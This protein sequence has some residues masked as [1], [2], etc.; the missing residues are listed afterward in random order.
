MDNISQ[1]QLGS[2]Y[3]FIPKVKFSLIQSTSILSVGSLN[4]RR[5]K[6]FPGVTPPAPPP[7]AVTGP[8]GPGPGSG[9]GGAY[10][11]GP[12]GQK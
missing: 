11:S 9:P 10:G 2:S 1:G 5:Q 3:L 4:R 6:N 12:G 8:K 7:P